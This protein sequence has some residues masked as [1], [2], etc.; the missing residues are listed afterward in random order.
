MTIPIQLAIQGGGAKITYLLAALESVQALE[1]GGL[2]RVTRIAGT[3]AGAI[4]GALYA[5]GV[6]MRRARDAF[7]SDRH[8]LLRAFPA[9]GVALCAWK[10][11]HAT[12]VLERRSASRL[13][14]QT[15]R[16]SPDHR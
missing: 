15:S 5:A 2:L 9:A 6:D 12:A 16:Q 4:A 10:L 14:R 1:R 8:Q 3:S 13:A 11:T 7:E